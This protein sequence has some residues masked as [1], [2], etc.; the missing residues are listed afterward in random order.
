MLSYESMALKIKRQLESYVIENPAHDYLIEVNEEVFN[1][2]S[3]RIDDGDVYLPQHG[4]KKFY[5]KA[6]EYLHIEDIKIRTV[7]SHRELEKILDD[8]KVYC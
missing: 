4:D 7:S 2:L 1:Y 6:K 5:I 8:T 3:E